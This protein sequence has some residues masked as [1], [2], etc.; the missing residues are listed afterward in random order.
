MSGIVEAG[1]V[2]HQVE[3][4]NSA[5]SKLKKTVLRTDYTVLLG[6]GVR[7]KN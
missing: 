4:K 2:H 3:T 7:E 6:I 1:R 5:P